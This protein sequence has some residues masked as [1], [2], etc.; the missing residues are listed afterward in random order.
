MSNEK[1]PHTYFAHSYGADFSENTWTFEII[2]DYKVRA[3]EYA[4]VEKQEYTHLSQRIA[5][6]EK[7]LEGVNERIGKYANYFSLTLDGVQPET[8]ARDCDLM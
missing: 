4:I 5:D 8:A 3:G 2:G 7:Q 6:L 1:Q